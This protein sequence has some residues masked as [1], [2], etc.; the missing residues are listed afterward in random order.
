MSAGEPT[1]RV[2]SLD[3]DYLPGAELTHRHQ[4]VIDRIRFLTSCL[5]AL[6][7]TVHHLV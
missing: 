6:R 2:S 3:E 7:G 4:A 5:G 1:L